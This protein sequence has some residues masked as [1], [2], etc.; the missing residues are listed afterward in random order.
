METFYRALLHG[1]QRQLRLDTKPE[2][3]WESAM[4]A[5]DNLDGYIQDVVLA[6]GS[7]TIV[8]CIDEADRIF[9]QAYR[10]S[11]F[12]LFRSWHNARAEGRDNIWNRFILV[13]TYSTEAHLFIPDL[14]QS[15]FNVGT[16]IAL[17]DFTPDQVQELNLRHESPLQAGAEL[18]RLNDLIGGH[19][20]LTRLCLYALKYQS[21][22]LDDLDEHSR[23]D[24]GLFND[25]LEHLYAGVRMDAELTA[26][27]RSLLM[28]EP[29]M[30]QMT[31][32]RLRAAGIVAG[33]SI[34]SARSRCGL[35]REFFGRRLI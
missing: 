5:N 17:E 3:Y 32:V 35:Y 2:A 4:S 9:D 18:Q 24:F 6:E 29:V 25:H 30:S 8:W 21:L 33:N 7:G 1:F 20:Y 19:P 12:G 13:M 26:G 27:L 11:V 16:K 22:S 23:Q 31:F 15:P 14:H 10:G 28:G 34:S